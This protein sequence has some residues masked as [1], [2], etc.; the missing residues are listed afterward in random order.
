MSY[1]DFQWTPKQVQDLKWFWENEG[2]SARQI[3]EKFGLTRNAILGKVHRL[4]LAA[5]RESPDWYQRLSPEQKAAR[6]KE[7]KRL[8]EQRKSA[9]RKA[10]RHAN[11]FAPRQFTPRLA[12][13]QKIPDRPP[14]A[15]LN[16]GLLELT[17]H[18][19]KW[20]VTEGSPFFFCGHPSADH[21]SYCNHHFHRSI[22]K[23]AAQARVA[24]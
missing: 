21:S 1:L 8:T 9:R 19:C 10:E 18:T 16:L 11:G 14:D 2:Y 4:G 12:T 6:R 5:R 15:P 13:W 3:G 23:Q 24:A 20:P 7:K 22:N 17:N